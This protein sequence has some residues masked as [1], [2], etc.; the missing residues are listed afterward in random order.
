[1]NIDINNVSGFIN[2]TT[3]SYSAPINFNVGDGVL[4]SYDNLLLNTTCKEGWKAPPCNPPQTG[5][6]VY[7]PQGTPLPLKNEVI[8]AELPKDSMFIF[9]NATANPVCRSQYSSDRGQLCLGP[10]EIKYIGEM[11]GFNKTYE[12]YNF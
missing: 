8:Y 2:K 10:N 9:S 3:A 6:R 7:V 11:R 4:G 5:N 1:M 12:N